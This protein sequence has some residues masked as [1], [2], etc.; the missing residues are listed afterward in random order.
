M[1]D[2]RF[3]H[4]ESSFATYISESDIQDML[5]CSEYCI[6]LWSEDGGVV[7]CSLLAL[8]FLDVLNGDAM[9][10]KINFA[11][12]HGNTSFEWRHRKRDGLLVDCHIRMTTAKYRGKKVICSFIQQIKLESSP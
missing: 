11:F 12:K 10:Q 9:R 5:K 7:D 6:A 4:D 2:T 3:Q 1:K 8:E